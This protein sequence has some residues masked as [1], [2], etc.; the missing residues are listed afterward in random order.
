LAV[1]HG[2]EDIVTVK[3][4]PVDSFQRSTQ[5]KPVTR[6]MIADQIADLCKRSVLLGD[7]SQYSERRS[8]LLLQWP[9]GAKAPDTHAIG[10]G[11]YAKWLAAVEVLLPDKS[12]DADIA[13]ELGLTI[14]RNEDLRRLFDPDIDASSEQKRLLRLE[15][16][17]NWT[18]PAK[19]RDSRRDGILRQLLELLNAKIRV[20]AFRR[21]TPDEFF[22]YA[23]P[24]PKGAKCVGRRAIDVFQDWL[25]T[26]ITLPVAPDADSER[27]ANLD[28]ALSCQACRFVENLKDRFGHPDAHRILACIHAPANA[29]AREQLATAVQS[30]VYRAWQPHANGVNRTWRLCVRVSLAPGR[31]RRS[32]LTSLAGHFGVALPGD[33][34]FAQSGRPVNL[35]RDLRAI[36]EI[37]TALPILLIF[38]DWDNVGGPYGSLHD[39]LSNSH[40]GEFLRVLAQPARGVL[41]AGSRP[42][43]PPSRIL[44]VSSRT[45]AELEPWLCRSEEIA[46]TPPTTG[47]GWHTNGVL[48]SREIEPSLPRE[49]IR[50]G[51]GETHFARTTNAATRGADAAIQML[52]LRFVAASVNGLQRSTLARC[53]SNWIE[54]FGWPS[55]CASDSIGN[56]HDASRVGNGDQA[57]GFLKPESFGGLLRELIASCEGALHEI[58]EEEIEGLTTRIRDLELNRHPSIRPLAPSLPEVHSTIQFRSREARGAFFRAWVKFDEQP[59]GQESNPFHAAATVARVNFI[60]AVEFLQQATSQARHQA[61]H[62]SENGDTS[63][64]FVQSVYHGLMCAHLHVAKLTGTGYTQDGFHPAILPGQAQKRFRYL[65]TFLYRDCIEGGDWRLGRSFGRSELRLDLLTLFAFPVSGVAMLATPD[66]SGETLALPDLHVAEAALPDREIAIRGDLLIALGRAALDVGTEHG[67]KTADWAL[68]VLPGWHLPSPSTPSTNYGEQAKFAA[69]ATHLQAPTAQWEEFD[70]YALKLRLDFFQASG[71]PEIL[72]V[73]KDLCLQKL[74]ELGVSRGSIESLFLGLRQAIA[75]AERDASNLAQRI[76]QHLGDALDDLGRRVA[77]PKSRRAAIDILFRLGE[78]LATIADGKDTNR[79]DAAGEKS[80]TNVVPLETLVDFAI[81][82]SIYWIADRMRSAL[83]IDASVSLHW[84]ISGAKSFRYYIRILFKLARLVLDGTP[85]SQ[86]EAVQPIAEGLMRLGQNRLGVLTRHHFRYQREQISALLLESNRLRSWVRIR[87]ERSVSEYWMEWEKLH[88]TD[89][90]HFEEQQSAQRALVD[91]SARLARMEGPK[92]IGPTGVQ[93]GRQFAQSEIE[94]ASRAVARIE[95]ERARLRERGAA[96][97][98]RLISEIRAQCEILGESSTR[99]DEAERTLLAHGFQRTHA[100]RFLVERMKFATTLVRILSPTSL[101]FGD[102]KSP[103]AR[104]ANAIVSFSQTKSELRSIARA[105]KCRRHLEF[106]NYALAS[107]RATSLGDPFW[108]AIYRRQLFG[109]HWAVDASSELLESEEISPSC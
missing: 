60:L 6:K 1:E 100:R 52:A 80:A 5:P 40:W 21:I 18:I 91:A 81:A 55:V 49:E 50:S 101:G 33:D 82:C 51:A 84:P 28:G 43:I 97:T 4:A 67:R 79:M 75:E 78:I 85:R 16:Q 7:Q 10:L 12:G 57:L 99:L 47:A 25:R 36:R 107:L 94:A 69:L 11:T 109:L 56:A 15:L 35:Y 89:R 48:G 61:A 32:V 104:T 38:E 20:S 65:W 71:S 13:S 77:T 19:K 17:Y 54:T 106:A 98:R 63:R 87:V 34:E 37:L 62:S 92:R 90:R 31:S 70:R 24:L 22:A 73:G 102:P 9:P 53:L 105:M 41:I 95:R 83:A 30:E 68:S 45:P 27:E 59:F 58:G 64:R 72:E 14:P 29:P 8:H 93:P 103:V 86:R 26:G 66:V 108:D 46:S 88:E 76:F 3:S 44:I 23:T 96:A 2:S 42:A 74:L 39:Y